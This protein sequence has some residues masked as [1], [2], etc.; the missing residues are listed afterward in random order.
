M[1][2]QGE[3]MPGAKKG[4]DGAVQGVMDYSMGS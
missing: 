3:W 4:G 1:A 2:T